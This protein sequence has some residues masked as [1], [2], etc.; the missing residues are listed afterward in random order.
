[1]Q[2]RTPQGTR[3]AKTNYIWSLLESE[4]E[5]I[6]NRQTEKG[7]GDVQI[8]VETQKTLISILNK[9]LKMVKPKEKVIFSQKMS[10]EGNSDK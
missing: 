8:A 10:D 2:A 1:M 7:Y 5:D 3:K 4:G 6:L 9:D